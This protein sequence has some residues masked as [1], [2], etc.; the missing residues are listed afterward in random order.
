MSYLAK[1]KVPSRH[2][3][4]K[5][6]KQRRVV[7]VALLP[8]H[9]RRLDGKELRGN[10]ENSLYCVVVILDNYETFRYGFPHAKIESDMEVYGYTCEG[11]PCYNGDTLEKVDF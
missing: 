11:V 3:S 1:Y 8:P 7:A 6:G 4:R 2:I 9:V 5:D 10:I